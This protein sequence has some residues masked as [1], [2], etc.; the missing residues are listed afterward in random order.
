VTTNDPT[1]A[2]GSPRQRTGEP[3]P[4]TA[5][6]VQ[7]ARPAGG[8]LTPRTAHPAQRAA[9]EPTPRTAHPTQRAASEP[10]PR[11]AHPAQPGGPPVAGDDR[12]RSSMQRAASGG[13]GLQMLATLG[14]AAMA[15]TL[16]TVLTIVLVAATWY[17]RSYGS[18]AA[19]VF[20]YEAAWF[21]LLFAIMAGC[22]IAAAAM[23]WPFK[24]R[25]YG[26][27][28]VHAGLV[29]VIAGFGL[30]GGR[31]DGALECR[32]GD[33]AHVIQLP[34]DRM[35][36][37]IGGERRAIGFDPIQFGGP[38]SLPRYLLS[39]I[40]PL[41]DEGAVATDQPMFTG[42]DGVSVRCTG[43][44]LTGAQELGFAPSATD[45]TP[46]VR[47]RLLAQLPMDPG[48]TQVVEDRWLSADG[49]NLF[50]ARGLVEMTLGVTGSTLLAADLQKPD[51]GLHGRLRIYWQGRRYAVETTPGTEGRETVLTDDLAV[52][53]LRVLVRPRFNQATRGLDESTDAP[54]HPLVEYELGRGPAD[55]RQWART[56]C[57][58]WVLPL[59]TAADRPEAIFDHP[60]ML[61]GTPGSMGIAAQVVMGPE[62]TLVLRWYRRSSGFAGAVPLTVAA[63]QH[64][65]QQPVDLVGTAGGPMRLTLDLTWIPQAEP[66]PLPLRMLPE[67]AEQA[68]RWIR[69][70]ARRGGASASAWMARAPHP[71][72][73]QSL[74]VGGSEVLLSYQQDFYDLRERHG[75][76]V[77]LERFTAGTDPGGMMKA[78]YA[79]DVSII[80]ARGSATAAT[81]AH[82]SMNR[83]LD[84]NGVT[85]FQTSY[86]PET[87]TTGQPT[88]RQV[89]VL[90]AA[91]DP[92]RFWKWL[93]SVLIVAGTVIL[94]LIAGRATAAPAALARVGGTVTVLGLAGLVA[95]SLP[96]S[97]APP[98][99]LSTAEIGSLLIPGAILLI[100]AVLEGRRN[101]AKSTP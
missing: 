16:I 3:T 74:R 17:E 70:E 49:E 88:G 100:W 77:R 12:F 95:M 1:P 31:L 27:V 78:S 64:L 86:Y 79:S 87:D 43:V 81:T 4:R 76:A 57:A 59:D 92:G 28:V 62:R 67:K 96:A 66:A 8:E 42:P 26:F 7:G 83:R 20:I 5:H 97:L 38:P 98:L 18:A 22:V 53:W 94:Y 10:T 11:T 63:G 44:V 55:S 21:N 13:V 15:A 19:R 89:S 58:A 93:G 90:T 85:F 6:P 73:H 69:V 56:A 30:A 37:V 14:S 68:T 65:V 40:W 51:P 41:R 33:E 101:P 84:H 48:R 34:T 23:R 25:H 35:T 24:P 82:I 39:P 9:S 32:P 46:V 75:F 52:R 45:G 60:A 54:V 72:A 47:A 2:T 61:A 71:A 99:A 91:T 29:A 50:N 80:E 36:A